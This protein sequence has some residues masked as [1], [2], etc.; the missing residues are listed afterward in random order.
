V[1]ADS[2]HRWNSPV[3]TFEVESR[4]STLTLEV[5]DIVSNQQHFLGRLE[6]GLRDA[7][8]EPDPRHDRSE[9]RGD[10]ND[11]HDSG[12]PHRERDDRDRDRGSDRQDG[13]DQAQRPL[14]FRRELAGLHHRAELDFSCLYEPFGT[15]VSHPSRHPRDGIPRQQRP[16]QQRLHD[17]HRQE[18]RDSTGSRAVAGRAHRAHSMHS[19]AS[20]CGDKIGVLSVRVV[21]AYNLV[22]MDSGYLGDVSDPYVTVR[23]RSQGDRLKPKRTQTVDNTLDPVWNTSPFLFELMHEDDELLLEVFDEDLVTK[24]DF[25]GRMTVPLLTIVCGKPDTAVRIR[26]S[27]QD[28][29]RGELE[30]EIGFS[31]G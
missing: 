13:P 17:S 21:A 9:R 1:N 28:I 10:R 23:L 4:T 30:L 25:M 12:Q 14:H 22:N 6:L 31:L 19:N 7:V 27:L 3:M 16:R 24:D 5:W 2:D 20:S 15:E 11:R 26:D 29:D 18:R 8:I